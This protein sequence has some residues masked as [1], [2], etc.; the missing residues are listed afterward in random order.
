[1]KPLTVMAVIRRQK[2]LTQYDVA[3]VAN[4]TQAEIS[5]IERRMTNPKEETLCMISKLLEI[6]AEELL[7]TYED[8][9]AKRLQDQGKEIV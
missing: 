4:V 7:V 6:P 1:M 8:W 5:L 9:V 3:D 2:K